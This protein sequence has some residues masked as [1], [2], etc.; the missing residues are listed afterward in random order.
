MGLYWTALRVYVGHHT[1]AQVVV[2]YAFGA[3]SCGAVYAG[4]FYGLS[5]DRL[6]QFPYGGR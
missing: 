1:L 2:G 6:H 3:I 5:P 4:G